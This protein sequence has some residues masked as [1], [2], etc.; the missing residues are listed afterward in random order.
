MIPKNIDDKL[1]KVKTKTDK[2]SHLLP[3]VKACKN[4]ENK[5]CIY[6]CPAGVYEWSVQ[7]QEIIVKFENCLE[8]GACRIACDSQTL[9]WSYPKSQYGI[10]YKKG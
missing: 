8:C 6:V 3:D 2:N 5:S 10:T 1:A 7:N 9:K 4:C